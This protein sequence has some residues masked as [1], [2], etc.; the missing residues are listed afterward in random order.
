MVAHIAPPEITSFTDTGLTNGVEYCYKVSAYQE[1]CE[2]GFGNILCAVPENQGRT[3]AT[4]GVSDMQAGMYAGK[5]TNTEFIAQSTFAA[6]DTVVVRFLVLD[7]TGRP[8]SNATVEIV[9]GGPET[10]TLNGNPSDA[11][12]WAEAAWQTH[13]PN[14]K[15]QGGTSPGAYTATTTNVT[16]P[17]TTGT[18]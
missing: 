17:D 8:V 13:A 14:K 4:A 3:G 12:G 15:G 5:G 9:I 11:D 7:E 10:T 2:Y 18:A 16:R 1:T 6:G